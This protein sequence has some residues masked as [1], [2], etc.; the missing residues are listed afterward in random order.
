MIQLSPSKLNVL[1][2]CPRCFWLENVRGIKRPRGA[3]PSLPGG[4]DKVLKAH[5]DTRRGEIVRCGPD[6]IG[7]LMTNMATLNGWR[8]WRSGLVYI[9]PELNVKMV[10]ALDDCLVDAEKYYIPLDYKTKGSQPKTDGSEYYQGQL[11]CYILMLESNGFKTRR[12][13]YLKY[14]WP[15]EVKPGTLMDLEF[16]TATYPIKCDPDRAIAAVAEAV[17]VMGL[18]EAPLAGAECEYCKYVFEQ[19]NIKR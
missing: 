18:K 3:F 14:V 4:M 16:D 9:N 17:R 7:F 15:V 12:M 8:N 2:E 19:D 11:D 6:E 5:Y 10:G 13:G 1:K